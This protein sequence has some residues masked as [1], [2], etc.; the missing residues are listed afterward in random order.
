MRLAA[1][2]ALVLALGAGSVAAGEVL[3][4]IRDG[5]TVRFG[6]R[7]DA[8]PLSYLDENETP[9]GYS[10]LVCEA[11]A[12]SLGRQLGRELAVDWRPVTAEN[13]FDKVAAGEIDL[14]CGAATI[15]LA[16][17]ERVDFSLPT[18]VDGAAVMLPRD[19]EPEFDALAG[20][21]IGVHAGT[22]TEAILGNSLKAKGMQAEVVPFDSHDAALAALEEGK[23]DAYFADQSILFGLFF[24]SDLSESLVVSE[25]TL[26]VEKQGL[27][28]PR[29]DGDFRLAVDR[30]LSELYTSGKMAEF[31]ATAFPGA[32]PGAALEALFLLA[33]ELP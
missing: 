5:G 17:R 24:A 29:G 10:V 4:R 26:T 1:S 30:A 7:E 19:A 33:P 9:A 16:R 27:A 22:T 14:L 20:K 18:F 31:F 15:T 32:T 6:Y 23:V 3:D 8:A 12:A 25:N 13:R 21:K 2:V 11:V 28:M